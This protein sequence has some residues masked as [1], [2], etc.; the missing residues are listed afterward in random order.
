MTAPLLLDLFCG[1]GGCSEGYRRAGFSVIGADIAD[2]S[3]A[4]R[5]TGALFV[6]FARLDWREALRVFGR[7]AAVISASPPCQRD[8]K[9]SHCRP[10]LAATYPDLVP[11]VREALIATGKPWVIEQPDNPGARSKLPGAVKL[12]GT[13]FGLTTEFPPYG[14]VELRRERLFGSNVPLEGAPCAHRHT[15][16][17]VFG[18]GRPGNCDLRGP[19]YAR[20]CREV[21]GIG[22]M[23][24]DE[25]CEAIPPAFTF[26]IG[27]Q[28]LASL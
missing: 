22:W 9:G 4:M 5:K 11:E 24:R 21:M 25:L 6:Q 7:Q 10:G 8:S 16:I 28:L 26:H 23:N 1:G 19:G 2:H 15:A 12:C 14:T 17:R 27:R 13:A 18:H 20:A 3:R